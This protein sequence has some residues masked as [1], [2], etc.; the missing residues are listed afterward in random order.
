MIWTA[1][2]TG[3]RRGEI[4]EL[5]RSRVNLSKGIISLGPEH[6]KE[7]QW[8]RVAVHNE[9]V[10]ILEQAMKVSSLGSGRVFL[11]WNDEGVRPPTLEAVK[12]PWGRAVE[13]IKREL[14]KAQNA[15]KHVKPWP[16]F[17]DL[18][19]TWKPNAR[20]SKMHPEIEKA[21]MG[22]SELGLSVHERYGRISDHELEQAIDRMTFDHGKTEI[23]VA[24]G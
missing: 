16:R 22:H 13:A 6:T 17:H 14:E 5:T 8:K 20:R 1:Y 2:F 19:H 18:R 23:C 12:N 3:M 10:P 11:L 9:L 15:G 24:G 4:V 21:I 7:G